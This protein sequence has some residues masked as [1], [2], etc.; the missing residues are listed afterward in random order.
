MSDVFDSIHAAHQAPVE[1]GRTP[2]GDIDLT[3]G[4]VPNEPEAPSPISH[5]LGDVTGIDHDSG[6]PIVKRVSKPQQKSTSEEVSPKAEKAAE[7]TAKEPALAEENSNTEAQPVGA[8]DPESGRTITQPTDNPA[9]NQALATDDMPEFRKGLE[10]ALKGVKGATLAASR[11]AKNPKRLAE[12]INSEGQP[13]ETVSDYGAAQISVDTPDALKV[14]VK[15]IKD[16]FPI[17]KED[18]NFKEGDKEFGYRNYSLQVQMPNGSS[19]EL[20]IV[21]K[22]VLD[23]NPDQHKEYK[24][25]RDKEIAGQDASAEKQAARDKNDA[26]MAKFNERNASTFTKGQP[27]VTA[28]GKS[29]TVSYVD[30]QM[31]IVRVK[32][33]DGK[34]L[35][36]P[37]AKVKPSESHVAVSA[38]FRRSAAK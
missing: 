31:K 36:L 15:A 25:A 12:K 27:V 13:P 23:A 24:D 29:A 9:K 1:D 21:P 37:T 18:D 2:Q 10:S 33:E 32:T 8:K 17:V 6:L 4:F 11:D 26:A 3:A 14:V 5:P 35:T 22:E 20:Q 38:H 16:K 34:N 19:Q 28:D 30:Q 7:K